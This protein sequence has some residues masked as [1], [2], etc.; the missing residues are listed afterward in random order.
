MVFLLFWPA[1]IA[2]FVASGFGIVR[3]RPR[4]LLCGTLL[5]VP[6]SLYLAATPRFTNAVY[7]L[8]LCHLFGAVAVQYNFQWL[9]WL[10]LILFGGGFWGMILSLLW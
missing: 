5:A 1:I 4:W 2:S 7:L 9:A 3:R 10:L 6:F 8:P